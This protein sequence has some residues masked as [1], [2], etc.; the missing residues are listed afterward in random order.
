MKKYKIETKSVQE[1][2]LL[3]LY[4]KKIAVEMYP[5]LFEDQ[6]AIDTW[7]KIDYNMAKMSKFKLKFGAVMVATRQYDL[8]TV[9]RRY[10]ADNP[11]ASVVNMG[12]GLDATFSMVSN[13]Q[14]QGYNIDFQ[15]VIDIRNQLLPPSQ[16]EK[17]IVADL[18]DYSWFDKIDF[19]P[20]KGAVFIASGVFYY[21]KKEAVRNLIVNMAEAFPSAKIVFDAT[22]AKGLKKLLSFW[23][24]ST[25]M[26]EVGAH[27]SIENIDEIKTWSNKIKTVS[28]K[29]YMTGYRPLDKCY[30]FILN[31]AFKYFD[32][33]KLGSI[34]E[35]EFAKH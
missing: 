25:D 7:S 35:I 18:T 6:T 33:A 12:C 20:A 34:I 28:R 26:A 32:N 24:V 27:F 16:L 2:L 9:C 11:A 3:P 17:N 30:G 1:T 19:N 15:D 14:A 10:L 5:D 23:L 22:N 21:F 8:A 29:G 31:M 4:G 13:G